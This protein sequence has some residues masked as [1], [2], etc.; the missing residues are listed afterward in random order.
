ML[1][2][3]PFRNPE[4][5]ADP[6]WLQRAI[7][8]TKSKQDSAY[9]STRRKNQKRTLVVAVAAGITGLVLWHFIA[10]REAK[11]APTKPTTIPKVMLGV[12]IGDGTVLE[13]VAAPD[14]IDVVVANEGKQIGIKAPA[15]PID[16]VVSVPNTVAPIET[17]EL[18]EGVTLVAGNLG[19][20]RDL[21]FRVSQP[22]AMA[23][24][25]VVANATH[26]RI[27]VQ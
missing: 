5:E 2:V 6:Q 25:D 22:S 17:Y 4:S 14:D 11:S 19:F 18:G 3:N 10:G 8:E 13:S 12:S 7:R 24:I 26:L 20:D 23:S 9:K 21:I 1:I 27:F 15:F 16:V